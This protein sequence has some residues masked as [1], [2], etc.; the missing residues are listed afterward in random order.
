MILRPQAECAFKEVIC[1]QLLHRKEIGGK[2]EMSHAQDTLA[3][4]AK[5]HSATVHLT[6]SSTSSL[7]IRRLHRAVIHLGSAVLPSLI[8]G[9]HQAVSVGD[10]AISISSRVWAHSAIIYCCFQ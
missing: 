7:S 9:L 8:P 5:N 2:I 1:S 3:V 10:M 6:E 4:A